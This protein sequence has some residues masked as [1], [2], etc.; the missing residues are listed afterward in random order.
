L[1]ATSVIGQ[2]INKVYKKVSGW[3]S[4]IPG[5]NSMMKDKV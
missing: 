2:G 1:L 3:L 4:K 5:I